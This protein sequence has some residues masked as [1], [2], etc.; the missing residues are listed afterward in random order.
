MPS[1]N[2]QQQ[3][4]LALIPKFSSFLSLFGSGWI[5]IE[6]ISQ[7]NQKL[8]R[9]YHRLLLAMSVYDILESVWNFGSTWP[10]PK[11]TPGIIWPMGTT[12]TCTAQ[13]FFLQLSLAVPMYNA[14]LSFYY[15]L[16]INYNYTD[17]QLRRW[18][19]PIMHV[20][21]FLYPFGTAF[22]S[23]VTGLMNNA[24]LWCWIAPLPGDC[25]DSN[26]HG[27]IEDGNANPCIRGDNAWIYRWA[28]YFCP[29]WVCI[30]FGS[31]CVCCSSCLLLYIV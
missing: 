18:V 5:F 10:I 27:T 4:A 30:F 1:W 26:R 8:N 15:L 6:V 9:P 13:G 19:E 12:A 25:L 21:C 23:A 24:N 11:G 17:R 16:V 14:C 22:Y 29:L 3:I 2:R 20:I 31:K 28:F 7:P